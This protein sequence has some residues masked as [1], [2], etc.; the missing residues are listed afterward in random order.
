V[1]F[2]AVHPIGS[3]ATP[4]C[5]IARSSFAP[6]QPGAVRGN[7]MELVGIVMLGSVALWLLQHFDRSTQW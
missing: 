3:Q 2:V 7:R 5:N 1:R 4:H 6:R